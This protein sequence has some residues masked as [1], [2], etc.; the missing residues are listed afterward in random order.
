MRFLHAILAHKKCLIALGVV[1][2]I[3]FNI[4]PSNDRDW[5]PNQAVLAHAEIDGDI[6]TIRNARTFRY[7]DEQNFTPAYKDWTLD[8]K[9]LDSLWFVLS[10]FSKWTGPAHTMLSFGFG[11]EYV[12]ISIEARKESDESFSALS[13][14]LKQ[15]ELM[16][17]IGDERDLVG[18][19]TGQYKDD[20]FLYPVRTSKDY[21]DELF[22]EILEEANRLYEKPKFYHLLLDACTNG[23]ARHVNSVTGRRTIPFSYKVYIPAFADDLLYDI[24][25]IKTDLPF[26]E[27]RKHF[28]INGNAEGYENHKD[29]SR[30]IREFD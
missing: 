17:V 26:E 16:Y 28:Q 14:L 21:M 9:D 8:L 15:Y 13:G 30:K 20:V 12:V 10:P 18:L 24:R 27:A 23:I 3:W 2:I 11:D 1:L 25:L 5:Y 4:Q 6:V 19:R 22:I 7:V 29:F